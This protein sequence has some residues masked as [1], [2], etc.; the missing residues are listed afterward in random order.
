MEFLEAGKT[1]DA[2]HVL[3]NELT[4]LNVD[5]D[6]LHTLSRYGLWFKKS[7]RTSNRVPAASLCA[8]NQRICGGEQ[9][10]MVPLD[11]RVSSCWMHYTVC[12]PL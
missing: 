6:H 4:P 3:R 1:T 11:H 10:G 2:L 5:P 9:V 12:W 8:Q 7:R